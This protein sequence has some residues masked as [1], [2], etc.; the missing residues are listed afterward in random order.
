MKFN[1]FMQYYKVKVFIKKSIKNVAWKLVP[2]PFNF[3]RILYKKESEK[4]S[5]LIWTNFDD[6]L[7]HMSNLSRLLQ[8]IHF[9]IDDVL[10]SLQTQ[11]FVQFFDEIISFGI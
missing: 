8:K 10:N 5:M 4:A 1:Q 2:L 11:D 9:P 3:Q 7:L 6:L